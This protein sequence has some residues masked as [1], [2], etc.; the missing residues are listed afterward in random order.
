MTLSLKKKK[1]GERGEKE[2]QEFGRSKCRGYKSEKFRAWVRSAMKVRGR[3]IRRGRI[4]LETSWP[5]RSFL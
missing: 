5:S 3:G 4:Y 2:V 1:S